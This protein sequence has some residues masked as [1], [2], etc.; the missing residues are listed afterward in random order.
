MKA[1]FNSRIT[2]SSDN[3]IKTSN[4]AFCYG[5]G[6]FETIVTGVGRI[7]LIDIHLDRLRR[8]CT[9]MGIQFPIALSSENVS[10][11]ISELASLNNLKGTI[12]AKLTIWRNEGGLYSPSNQTASYYMDVKESDSPPYDGLR[13][14]G[15][16]EIHH[17]QFSPISF[18]KTTSALTYVLAGREKVQRQ[19]DEI[20]LTDTKGNLSETHIANLYWIIGS[21]IFT[22]SISTGCIAGV[23]RSYILEF[24]RNKNNPIKEVRMTKD[25]LGHAESIFI[26][27][28]SG[29]RYFRIYNEK[30]LINPEHLLRDVLK[31]LQRP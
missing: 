20:I 30:T 21:Q 29:I 26:S 19:Y 28:A 12:R 5:D 13:E 6:L 9:V 2:D 11:M 4:R 17:T 1:I 3:L 24:Y 15:I 27:N 18:A 22:P 31:Q 23:M 8:A 16:S 7:N 10:Q 14:I 25:A